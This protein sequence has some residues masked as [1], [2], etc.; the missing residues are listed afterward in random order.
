MC[1][2]GQTPHIEVLV[3][4]ESGEE[5]P[6][7]EIWLLWAGG[8]DR[9]VSGLKPGY[10]VGYV[11]FNVEADVS[12]TLAIGELSMPLVTGLQIRLCPDDD[13]GETLL[14][15]WRVEIERQSIEAE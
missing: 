3:R 14:T 6:G 10:G 8:A 2:E 12:Y 1:E 4:D 7:I 15:S 13:S 9:A 5:L 11:D